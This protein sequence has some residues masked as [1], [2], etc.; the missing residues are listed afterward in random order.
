MTNLNKPKMT[1]EPDIARL[2]YLQAVVK[3]LFRL[4]PPCE[5]SFSHESSEDYGRLIGFEVAPR[6]Q[7]LINIYALHRGPSVWANAEDFDP[8]RFIAH[9]EVDM[10]GHHF[11]LVP[12]DGGRRQCPSKKLAILYVQSGLAQYFQSARFSG[13]K[14]K[15]DI[16]FHA[17]PSA[18]VEARTCA[19]LGKQACSVFSLPPLAELSD[20]F[21][22]LSA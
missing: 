1:D 12:F 22:K 10:Q 5:F 21:Q 13:C 19:A 9:P 2:P 17:I 11:Q 16:L 7:V 20:C 15:V 18:A 4:H 6:T 3:E 8:G 14:L